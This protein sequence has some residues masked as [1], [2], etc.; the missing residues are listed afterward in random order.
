MEAQMTDQVARRQDPRRNVVEWLKSG[1]IEAELKRALPDHIPLDWFLRCAQTALLNNP[2]LASANKESLLRELV[3]VAQLG[4]VTDPQLGEAWLIID[5]HGQV[6]RRVG[7]QGLRKLAL[8]SG[9]IQSLNAQAV[10]RKDSCSIALGDSPHVKHEVDTEIDDRGDVRGYYAVA[11]VAGV[12]EPVVEWMSK[13]QVDEHRDRYSDAYRHPDPK[14]RGPWADPLGEVEMGRKTVFRRLAKWLPK[15]PILADALAHEDRQDM[16]DVTPGT[17]M[18]PAPDE[19]DDPMDRVVAE[20]RGKGDASSA[21]VDGPTA[22][23][24]AEPPKRRPGRP[25]AQAT[26]AREIIAEIEAT[27]PEYLDDYLAQRRRDIDALDT[28]F[29]Y[30][31]HAA[32]GDK[33]RALP[34]DDAH[35]ELEIE[36]ASDPLDVEGKPLIGEM[37]SDADDFEAWRSDM[38]AVMAAERPE[39]LRAKRNQFLAEAQELWGSD[40]V[41]AVEDA[42]AARG[43]KP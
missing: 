33:R 25:K 39:F 11:R 1:Y 35:Q 20:A 27:E 3:A 2:N 28:G 31:V 19:P 41:I 40:G 7:Y 26:I 10:F 18:L 30:D 38:S 5:R 13:K 4:L 32:A 9:L 22:P 17:G 8:N 43:G 6:Q 24:A 16:R 14:K 15:S 12:S 34:E 42:Y 29:Q 37:P 23:S 21:A 36:P